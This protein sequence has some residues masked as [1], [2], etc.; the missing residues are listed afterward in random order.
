MPQLFY[1][2]HAKKK[3][4]EE[5]RIYNSKSLHILK[6]PQNHLYTYRKSYLSGELLHQTDS[7]TTTRS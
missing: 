2:L 6:N 7:N 4:V 3:K 1:P 5:I